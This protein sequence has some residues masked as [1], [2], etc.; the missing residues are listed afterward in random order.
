MRPHHNLLYCLLLHRCPSLPV[1]I[2]ESFLS[3]DST[4]KQQRHQLSQLASTLP[5]VQAESIRNETDISSFLHNRP[6]TM[7]AP[8]QGRQSPEPETQSD[9]QQQTSAKPNDQGAAPSKDHAAD[10]SKET[11]KNL[12]SNPTGVLE[13]EAQKKTAKN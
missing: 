7:S 12:E 6:I 13:A 4:C 8:K 11:L 3:R 10:A 9:A 5:E 2:V 1:G